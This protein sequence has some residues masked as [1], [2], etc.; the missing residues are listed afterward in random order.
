MDWIVGTLVFFCVIG[1]AIVSPLAWKEE[2]M[3]RRRISEAENRAKSLEQELTRL[4]AQLEEVKRLNAALEQNKETWQKE[5]G[6]LSTQLSEAGANSQHLQA[7][8]TE[9]ERQLRTEQERYRAELA[10]AQEALR[11]RARSTATPSSS[12][13]CSPAHGGGPQV[14]EPNV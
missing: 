13:A 12:D 9:L 2:A 1:A 8:V 10:A 14:S 11:Q 4:N 7:R 6:H 5:L 3:H